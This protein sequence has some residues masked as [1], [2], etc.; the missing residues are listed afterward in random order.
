MKKFL[1]ILGISF[2]A[3]IGVVGV[4]IG[5]FALTGGFVKKEIHL[6]KIFFESQDV[7][8]KTVMI[9]D[10]LK[11][12]VINY[13]PEDATEK[14]LKCIIDGNA[15]SVPDKIYVGQPF[16]IVVNKD[17][18]G[19]NIGG[20]VELEFISN[21]SSGDSK[22]VSPCKMNIVVDV[23]V[24][25]NDLLFE[26]SLKMNS[27]TSSV[28]QYIIAKNKTSTSFYLKS[29]KDNIFNVNQWTLEN[30]KEVYFSYIIDDDEEKKLT[31]NEESQDCPIYFTYDTDED[32]YALTF[33][34]SRLS[35]NIVRVVSKI[36]RTNKIQEEFNSNNYGEYATRATLT[37]AELES[38]KAFLRKYQSYF[39]NTPTA[40]QFFNNMDTWGSNYKIRIQES[41]QYVFV[42]A[43]IDFYVS[44]IK[45]TSFNVTDVIE[46][47]WANINSNGDIINTQDVYINDS[48]YIDIIDMFNITIGA[49]NSSN[50]TASND[51]I[52]VLLQDMEIDVLVYDSEKKSKLDPIKNFKPKNNSNAEYNYNEIEATYQKQIDTNPNDNNVWTIGS[53]TNYLEVIKNG[54]EANTHW[55]FI[56][57]IPSKDNKIFQIYLRFTINVVGEDGEKIFYDYAKVNILDT[58]D[59]DENGIALNTGISS[60][61]SSSMYYS[62]T[63]NTL[64]TAT[65][66]KQELNNP[67]EAKVQPY[68]DVIL[69]SSAYRLFAYL[70]YK[71]ADGNMVYDDPESSDKRSIY[72]KSLFGEEYYP[73]FEIDESRVR[74]FVDMNGNNLV[75]DVNNKSFKYGEGN[76]VYAYELDWGELLALC[77][78]KNNVTIAGAYILGNT[79]VGTDGKSS[80]IPLT[81]EGQDISSQT[82]T[83]NG[84]TTEYSEYVT[85]SDVRFATNYIQV[86][87]V[88]E[89]LYYY[90]Q[91]QSNV[92]IGDNTYNK[93]DLILRNKNYLKLIEG[94]DY[95]DV[96]YILPYNYDDLVR[97][98]NKNAD[99]DK[100]KTL[101]AMIDNNTASDENIAEY[102]ELLDKLKDIDALHIKLSNKLL[103]WQDYVAKVKEKGDKI[104]NNNEYFTTSIKYKD[105]DDIYA[106]GGYELGVGESSITIHPIIVS[107]NANKVTIS[108]S[109]PMLSL[110]SSYIPSVYLSD[111]S[112][113]VDIQRVNVT[114]I[115][116][117][118]ASNSQT[119]SISDKPNEISATGE[120]KTDVDVPYWAKDSIYNIITNS[121]CYW[122]MIF[123][124]NNEAFDFTNTTNN[125]NNNDSKISDIEGY[126]N[127]SNYDT[128]IIDMS[129]VTDKYE[130]MQKLIVS[131]MFDV[132]NVMSKTLDELIEEV[133]TKLNSDSDNTYLYNMDNISYTYDTGNAQNRNGVYVKLDKMRKIL[134]ETKMTITDISAFG[135]YFTETR[136]GSVNDAFVIKLVDDKLPIISMDNKYLDITAEDY[137]I[138]G[139]NEK[140]KK[141]TQIDVYECVTVEEE[142]YSTYFEKDM[143]YVKAGANGDPDICYIK[144][145]K[146]GTLPL[147]EFNGKIVV[148]FSM[149]W[150]FHN[151]EDTSTN[152]LLFS[153]TA[154]GSRPDLSF[155]GTN[156]KD[157]NNDGVS[158]AIDA[159]DAIAI[160]GGNRSI[161][162]DNLISYLNIGGDSSANS[163]FA[164]HLRFVLDNTTSAY[165]TIGTDTTPHYSA[166][167]S[168]DTESKPTLNFYDMIQPKEVTITCVF[169]N[170]EL[171]LVF[172]V[173]ANKAIDDSTLDSAILV[174]ST[175]HDLSTYITY[176][177]SSSTAITDIEI[178][179]VW[180]EKMASTNNWVQMDTSSQTL[181]SEVLAAGVETST[182]LQIGK[183]YLR[184]KV[185]ISV[186]YD[187]TF[188][189][190]ELY[191]NNTYIIYIYPQEKISINKATSVND[192]EYYMW[193][194]NGLL[195]NGQSVY[196]NVFT[197][198]EIQKIE[199]DGKVKYINEYEDIDISQLNNLTNKLNITADIGLNNLVWTD[200]YYYYDEKKDENQFVSASYDVKD[201]FYNGTNKT[202]LGNMISNTIINNGMLNFDYFINQSFVLPIKV[203]LTDSVI[204]GVNNI[205]ILIPIAGY[206]VLY[207]ETGSGNISDY[208]L[209]PYD[210][211]NHKYSF[212]GVAFGS[213]TH[214]LNDHFIIRYAGS[215]VIKTLVLDEVNKYFVV[216]DNSIGYWLKFDV[217]TNNPSEYVSIDSTGMIMTISDDAFAPF[218]YSLKITHYCYNIGNAKKETEFTFPF[219]IKIDGYDIG[220]NVISI[221]SNVANTTIDVDKDTTILSLMKMYLNIV[222]KSPANTV[223]TNTQS[224]TSNNVELDATKVIIDDNKTIRY[225]L[226]TEK[227]IK[228]VF[229]KPVIDLDNPL[230]AMLASTLVN[231][232]TLN[233]YINNSLWT[234]G[235][236][237]NLVDFQIEYNSTITSAVE[238]GV[239]IENF[240]KHY[241]FKL[242]RHS[243]GN[244]VETI[245]LWELVDNITFDSASQV[246]YTIDDINKITFNFGSEVLEEVD[247]NGD[248]VIQFKSPNAS[249]EFGVNDTPTVSTSNT[250]VS[251]VAFE[252]EYTGGT[253][254]L[255]IQ[256]GKA[257]SDVLKNNF[258][259]IIKDNTSATKTVVFDEADINQKLVSVSD[260]EFYY[261]IDGDNKIIFTF[262]NSVLSTINGEI[263]FNTIISET[264]IIKINNTELSNLSTEFAVVE[265]TS[266]INTSVNVVAGSSVKDFINRYMNVKVLK[267][268]SSTTESVA[269]N[270][271]NIKVVD[272]KNIKYNLDAW[273]TLSVQFD[274]DTVDVANNKILDSA[275]SVDVTISINNVVKQNATSVTIAQYVVSKDNGASDVSVYKGA[276][277][278]VINNVIAGKFTLNIT[279][280]DTTIETIDFADTSRINYTS[281]S[282]MY[283]DID[284]VNR[285]DFNYSSDI[286]D[287]NATYFQDKCFNAKLTIA[288]NGVSK[289]S[290]ALSIESYIYEFDHSAL[291]NKQIDTNTSILNFVSLC[292]IYKN[293]GTS[294]I[295]SGYVFDESK[296]NNITTNSFTYTDTDYS[297]EVTFTFSEG[298]INATGKKFYV[299]TKNNVA[300]TISGSST[301]SYTI[302]INVPTTEPTE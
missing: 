134:V 105:G 95:S 103:A 79:E 292:K 42:T 249:L 208:E 217:D 6:T 168:N 220:T 17:S 115:T 19:R 52:A 177:D 87:S 152:T 250:N 118:Y 3:V 227:Y 248:K 290:D 278:S 234:E 251:V 183:T 162:A 269:I 170:Q 14:E 142:E 107:I 173:E 203:S 46:L 244:V 281:A 209:L 180:Y 274:I 18:N 262:T 263:A 289:V 144:L 33:Y 282:A 238:V 120:M 94:I 124:I 135:S 230:G 91:Q 147:T 233:I 16:D 207:N 174:D 267:Y 228:F 20:N 185:E 295:V 48:N 252:L 64:G 24:E 39:V 279:K 181:V 25:D 93:G 280:P 237:L 186:T 12:V 76:T 184:L 163:G 210:N 247:N 129:L 128:S 291:N 10:D 86:S 90:T 246:T 57:K 68:S 125:V 179:N 243:A 31:I 130:Y 71:G 221:N 164:T 141:I 202:E 241:D 229:D 73:I 242:L 50:N 198:Q 212:D 216:K 218:E 69:P 171:K 169:G 67:A 302:T 276:N 34:P 131:Y 1:I 271:A 74:T 29:N 155:D 126:K 53:N 187:G 65:L 296:I 47:D 176:V 160:T 225:E 110:D 266:N 4:G 36:H 84:K 158:D 101:Q 13:L 300:L 56:S 261:S 301:A 226:D 284:G 224:D 2:A 260:K 191:N 178:K 277:N 78:S 239:S 194:K 136:E 298:V 117:M 123:G 75:Y 190:D 193:Q 92:K 119:Y 232:I 245:N 121:S 154:T 297:I 211:N 132:S 214:Y 231:D 106:I 293:N 299:E 99:I 149:L 159:R 5:V 189:A 140:Y 145:K 275:I 156:A 272:A 264:P 43:F 139:S 285:V 89:D 268:Q 116:E 28:N 112:M 7:T 270:D 257:L 37:S 255:I 63:I 256:K 172:N 72:T 122:P 294:T 143:Y 77:A 114:G 58:S 83:I 288:V 111:D 287:S 59:T 35:S 283:Y 138:N 146:D 192:G 100:L 104:F 85:V 204:G 213:G 148:D 161:A 97:Y 30:N 175:T 199:D 236:Q 127:Y 182:K 55:T 82:I 108:S 8:D 40:L 133:V 137:T 200:T 22:L 222:D 54:V 215:D 253:T 205:I 150:T 102:Q 96:V 195:K 201:Q 44:D 9:E 38:Y 259:L 166:N 206:E 66:N 62:D 286:L 235:L 26:S 113:N 80:Y 109:R 258:K 15:V 45:V 197:I 240:F 21:A 70:G 81:R 51:E 157:S 49:T 153:L 32:R 41:Y 60:K 167:Y 11:D 188:S 61:I 265:Y 27:S 223:N 165:F 98:N 254:P 23:P 273:N 219:T 88:L 151:G 196:G